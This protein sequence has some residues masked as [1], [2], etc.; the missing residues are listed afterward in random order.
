MGDLSLIVNSKSVTHYLII[1][2]H[3]TCA[4]DDGFPC[5]IEVKL[6]KDHIPLGGRQAIIRTV[7]GNKVVG[8]LL[9]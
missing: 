6:E 9:C 1:T 3:T 5:L 8:N 4:G 7:L 2:G